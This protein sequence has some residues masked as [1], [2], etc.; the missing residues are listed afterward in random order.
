VASSIGYINSGRLRAIVVSKKTALL[1]NVPS[2]EEAGLPGTE[3]V[4]WHSVLALAE[5]PAEIVK[6]LNGVLVSILHQPQWS[7]HSPILAST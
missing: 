7:N 1:P 2:L 5:T 3:A 6:H 4:A